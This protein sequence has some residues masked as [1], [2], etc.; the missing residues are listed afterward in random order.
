VR[1]A[2]TCLGCHIFFPLV[3][4]DER[5]LL[6]YIANK[7]QKMPGHYTR[8]KDLQAFALVAHALAVAGG[9]TLGGLFIVH[10]NTC[11]ED[12]YDQDLATLMGVSGFISAVFAIVV[13]ILMLI[14]AR[15]V[16]EARKQCVKMQV[17]NDAYEPLIAEE[18]AVHQTDNN[19]HE[20]QVESNKNTARNLIISKFVLNLLAWGLNIVLGV[21]LALDWGNRCPID[22]E[23][24]EDGAV[25]FSILAFFYTV[26]VFVGQTA[27]AIVLIYMFYSL[28]TICNKEYGEKL[29]RF[30][31][32]VSEP[33]RRVGNKLRQRFI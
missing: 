5:I 16:S 21:F 27:M 18:T 11:L 15:F 25:S 19:S 1:E 7:N 12:E 6:R 9:L 4:Q 20:A 17:H 31:K 28:N 32:K 14:G 2:R 3:E 13:M 23:C 29:S 26:G 10:A 30:G 8:W 33:F 24:S 22:E